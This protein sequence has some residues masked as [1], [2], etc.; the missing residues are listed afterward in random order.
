MQLK[1]AVVHFGVLRRGS[2][3]LEGA[4]PY[5]PSARRKSCRGFH[6]DS[7]THDNRGGAAA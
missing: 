4:H 5:Q 6:R 2:S 1:A 3:V 7:S